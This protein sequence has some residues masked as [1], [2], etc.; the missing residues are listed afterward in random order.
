MLQAGKMQETANKI[1]KFQI[2]MVTLQ[3]IQWT[4]QGRIDKH[5]YT[6]ICSRSGKRTGQLGVGFM[7]TKAIRI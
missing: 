5:D 4:R 7:I 6:L 1:Q 2:G 3:G